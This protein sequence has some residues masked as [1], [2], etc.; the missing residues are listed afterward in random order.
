MY[1]VEMT[2]KENTA[3]FGMLCLMGDS[4]SS[5]I[6]GIYFYFFKTIDEGLYAMTVAY[7]IAL[8]IL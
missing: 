2:T 8:F 7:L 1:S 3:F 4:L 6:I 5:I